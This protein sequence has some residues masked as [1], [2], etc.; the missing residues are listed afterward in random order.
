MDKLMEDI[1]KFRD[2]R[3][4][5]QYHN[6]KDLTISLLIEAA[7]LLENFQWKTSEESVKLKIS[8][9]KDELGDVLI[10]SFLLADSMNLDVKELIADKLKKNNEKYPIE[11][12]FG[13]N[14]KYNEL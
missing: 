4:W 3:N 10:Y 14:K 11:K 13:S 5:K 12:A 6:P 9:I 2:E 8:K 1:T 7:E